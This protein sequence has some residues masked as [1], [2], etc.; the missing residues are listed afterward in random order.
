MIKCYAAAS[1]STLSVKSICLELVSVEKW[2]ARR[3]NPKDWHTVKI[4]IVK[5]EPVTSNE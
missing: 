1:G 3:P 5:V 2:I 4:E